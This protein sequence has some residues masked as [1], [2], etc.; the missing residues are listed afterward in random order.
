MVRDENTIAKETLFAIRLELDNRNLPL[1][2]CA[3]KGGIKYS[4]FLTWFP[5][6]G[7]PQ[8][9][10]IAWLPQLAKA[11]PND[12]FSLL[13]PDGFHMVPS[14]E[15]MD[16]DEFAAGCRAF[17]KAKDEAHHPS[18]PAGRDLSDCEKAKLNVVSLPLRG[19]VA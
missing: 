2:V 8:I 16:Y 13:L 11:L 5:A 15:G 9:P 10:S 4:T 17:T 3:A 14:P 1:K 6:N 19:K 18:S 7:D 12:L